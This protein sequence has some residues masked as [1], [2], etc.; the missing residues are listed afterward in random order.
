MVITLTVLGL[1]S[2]IEAVYHLVVPDKDAYLCTVLWKETLG[3][4]YTL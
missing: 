2:G 3:L 4:V 1:G